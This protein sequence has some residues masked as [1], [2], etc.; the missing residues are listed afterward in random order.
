MKRLYRIW[1]IYLLGRAI[2]FVGI[3]TFIDIILRHDIDLVRNVISGFIFIIIILLFRVLSCR[4]VFSRIKYLENNDITRPSIEG[5]CS[6]VIVLSQGVDFN[7]LKNEIANKWL[8][9]FSDDS[10][11]VLKF[12]RK[13]SFFNSANIWG[14]AGWLKFD[15]EAGE[16][17][18]ECF[19][20][21]G[22]QDAGFA[23]WLRMEIEDMFEPNEMNES[24]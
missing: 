9:T 23:S 12:M 22:I 14:A 11:H 20:M 19:P 15:C 5:V 4:S 2:L 21:A 16:I 3:L 13:I 24:T 7:G 10:N 8:I 6:S 18:L 17:Q 1:M